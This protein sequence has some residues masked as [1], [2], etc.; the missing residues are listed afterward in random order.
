MSINSYLWSSKNLLDF[1]SILGLRCSSNYKAY[2]HCR[3]AYPIKCTDVIL[4]D[5]KETVLEIRAE[6]DPS[7]TTKPKVGFLTLNSSVSWLV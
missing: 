4:A 3:Y 5:D 1:S 2:L 7:K 6:Y